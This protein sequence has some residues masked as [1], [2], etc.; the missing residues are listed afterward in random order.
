MLKKISVLFLAV[1]FSAVVAFAQTPATAPDTT[2][3]RS[4]ASGQ[5]YK[6]E[7]VVV[8]KDNDQTF[9][10]R[11][12]TGN[13]T[14]VVISPEASVKTKGGFFGGGDR[15]ASSQ[16]VRGLYLT[17]EGRG[18]GSGNLAATK[19]RF[20]KTDFRTAQS[21]DSR[22]TPAEARLN[23]AEENQ[24]KVAGQI[25]ELMAISNAAR[26]GAKAAQD[27]ADAAIAGVNATNQRISAM[28]DYVVQST[29][30]V[31]F[32]VGSAVLSPEAKA[33]LD[34]VA[35]ASQGL[36]GYSI[37]VTGFASSDGGTKMNKALSQRR[38]QAVID[39]MVETH[40]IPLR[41][42]GQSYGFGELQAVADNSTREGREQNRRV[43]VKLL[44]NRGINQ[45]VEVRQQAETTDQ[46]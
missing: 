17:A 2:Q 19:V 11:D 23:A 15:I 36:K 8:S 3:V 28:D 42:I 41:R 18:D 7:G 43:E 25:D 30:T 1:L 38:A 13:D 39:Y 9:I 40:N 5:K 26:G 35:T 32:R 21:I 46:Q 24:Q 22:V 37:E 6:I 14:R 27:T 10:I 44:V 34:E 20:D 29:A 45:N 16:I 4:L 33:S 12:T 31:N